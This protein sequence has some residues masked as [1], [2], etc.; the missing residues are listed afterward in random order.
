MIVRVTNLE[1]FRRFRDGVSSFDTEQSVIDTLSGV[2]VGNNKTFIGSAFHS[3]IEHGKD[4]NMLMADLKAHVRFSEKQ[5]EMAI[6]HSL[7]LQPFIPEIRQNK[8]FKTNFGI[9]T[10]S[11]AIDVLQGNQI[12]DTKTKFSSPEYLEY[13]D[14]YQWRIYLSIFGLDRFY[15]DI[16]EF[17]GYKDE[18]LL[19][20][21]GC[22]IKQHDPY[23]CLR[24][25]NLETDIIQLLNEF[26]EWVNFRKLQNLLK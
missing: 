21:S 7:S 9:I 22:G 24:Y 4:I 18:M 3:I 15:Y 25:D 13:F 10:L 16:F 2:F 26:I 20:V 12:R 14:S 23:E 19:D 5:I 11:G 8:D 6:N 1:K 17:I